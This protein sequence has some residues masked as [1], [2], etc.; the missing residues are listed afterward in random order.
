MKLILLSFI[1]LMNIVVIAQNVHRCMTPHA[2]DFQETLT[3]GYKALVQESFDNAKK[4][5]GLLK[6]DPI[7]TIPVVVHVVYNTAE[8]NIPD[9][10]IYDQI[11]VLTD[12]YNRWNADTVN[13]RADFEP[14]KGNPRIRFVLA[15][16][17]A[18]GNATTGITRTQTAVESFG[19]FALLT[20]SFAD[21]EKVKSTADG[22]HDPW[23][24][25]RYLNIWVCNMSLPLLGP[26]LLGYATPPPGLPNWPTGQTP[27]GLS[28]GVVI[29]FQAFGS[30]NPVP[31]QFGQTAFE[32][33]GRTCVHE[34]GHYL[35]LRHIWGDGD[36]SQ[37]DGID[38][39][40]NADSQ[41]NQD[42]DVTRNTCTDNIAGT[43]LPDMVE[44]YMDYSAE[45]C[46]NS[47]TNG[48]VQLMHGVLEDDRYD[49]VHNNP[50]V[51]SEEENLH[52]LVYPNPSAKVITVRTDITEKM[53]ITL[54]DVHGKLVYNSTFLNGFHQ[55]D[56]DEIAVGVYQLT[57][58][59][60]EYLNVKRVLKL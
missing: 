42:C 43:D 21:L 53:N 17:D 28:D 7:Y 39:T 13:M 6:A 8:Q 18:Q 25:S 34:V 55:I 33:A 32:V 38:D 47:W 2:I 15:Q 58:S 36:C 11:K 29:Q 49:L 12:D 50:A 19:S 59:N 10:V 23:D 46:Q 37:E 20:G 51:I 16:I 56:L 24:Q 4:K 1:L 57:I 5:G 40:P 9:S 35:G 3:P 60:S 31:L 41:S 45:T 22:G 44:N 48:Q 27:T 26:A 14:V 52:L 30:N 54:T